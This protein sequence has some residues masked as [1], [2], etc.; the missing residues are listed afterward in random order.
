MQQYRRLHENSEN[1]TKFIS[2]ESFE[3]IFY[4]N[5]ENMLIGKVCYY[6]YFLRLLRKSVIRKEKLFVRP[7]QWEIRKKYSW[8]IISFRYGEEKG[9]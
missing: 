8:V 3:T 6:S 2:P 4:L 5:S 1:N 7:Y 9:S